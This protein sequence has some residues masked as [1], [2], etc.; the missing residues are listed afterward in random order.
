M[1]G[2]VFVPGYL[3]VTPDPPF[4][5]NEVAEFNIWLDPLAAAEV[6]AAGETGLKIQLMPLDATDKLEFTREDYRARLDFGTPESITAAEFLDF[7][8]VVVENDV[9]PNPLW[10]MV[11]AI[12]LSEPDFSTEV[13]LHIEINVDS[14]PGESQGQT[15]AVEGLPPNALVSLDASFDNLPFDASELFSSLTATSQSV[16]ESNSVLAFLMTGIFGMTINIQN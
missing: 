11:A 1:G 7:S 2:A 10:D 12:N 5:T 9:N 14:P 4:S 6:F 16:P 8:L 3:A 15:V 13:P